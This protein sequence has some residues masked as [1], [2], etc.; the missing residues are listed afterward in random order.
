MTQTWK[1]VCRLSEEPYE[2]VKWRTPLQSRTTLKV[3]LGRIAAVV[4]SESAM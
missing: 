4:F 1:C 2:E 3:A